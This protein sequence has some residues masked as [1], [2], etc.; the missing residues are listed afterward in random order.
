MS[1]SYWIWDTLPCV[2]CPI[3][4]DWLNM[5]WMCLRR[6]RRFK[7]VLLIV[8]LYPVLFFLFLPF[9]CLLFPSSINLSFFSNLFFD[10]SYFKNKHLDERNTLKTHSYVWES[11][12]NMSFKH[13][14]LVVTGE[15]VANEEKNCIYVCLVSGLSVRGQNWCTL[16]NNTALDTQSVFNKCLLNEKNTP[17][18]SKLFL[19]FLA[20]SASPFIL[21]NI[22]KIL[23]VWILPL[24]YTFGWHSEALQNYKCLSWFLD[25]PSIFTLFLQIVLQSLAF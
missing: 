3:W 19:P 9:L 18:H 1:F 13:W 22:L 17:F 25:F 2:S 21:S 16:A 5:C 15:F 8:F 11:E 23:F 4:V 24:E 14:V 10:L 7:Y 6:M 12:L 20:Y